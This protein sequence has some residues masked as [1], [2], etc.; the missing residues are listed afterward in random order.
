MFARHT[1]APVSC[2]VADGCAKLFDTVSIEDGT[3]SCLA[4]D[5]KT[6]D[7]IVIPN[8]AGRVPRTGMIRTRKLSTAPKWSALWLFARVSTPI[9]S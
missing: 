1:L 9:V 5:V 7:A 2:I 8:I 3:N 6:Y 4:N